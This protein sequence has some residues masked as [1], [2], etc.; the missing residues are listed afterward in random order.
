MFLGSD[1]VNWLV[2]RGLCAGQAEAR[3]YAA[4]LQAGGVLDHLTSRQ[5][6]RDEPT[7]LYRFTQGGEEGWNM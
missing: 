2:E 3:L 5:S 4:R 7:L 1:L 6:F